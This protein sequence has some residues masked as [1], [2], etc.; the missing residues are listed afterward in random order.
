MTD[1]MTAK[2][3]VMDEVRRAEKS[4]RMQGQ[5]AYQ[6]AG[7]EEIIAELRPSLVRH[8]LAVHPARCKMLLQDK[9]TTSGGKTMTHTVVKIAFRLTHTSGQFEEGESIGEAA[10]NGDKS[11]NKALTA[12]LKYYLLQSFLLQSSYDDPDDYSSDT[13]ERMAHAGTAAPF[14]VQEPA[15]DYNA[16]LGQLRTVTGTALE[17]FRKEGGGLDKNDWWKLAL[18]V[19][20]Q[21]GSWPEPHKAAMVNQLVGCHF[22]R[23]IETG[24]TKAAAEAEASTLPDSW[25]SRLKELA[26]KKQDTPAEPVKEGSGIRIEEGR[27]KFAKKLTEVIIQFSDDQPVKLFHECYQQTIPPDELEFEKSLC[28]VRHLLKLVPEVADDEDQKWITSRIEL[29]KKKL[30]PAYIVP[31]EK[32]FAAKVEELK[33]RK[34][35]Q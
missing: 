35:S 34:V 23:R 19:D 31:L 1:L 21:C 4:R 33:A 32:A 27:A 5:G 28:R 26:T 15:K 18:S 7:A 17:R 2:L 8:G 3:L 24:D 11:C 9:L 14:S 6:Y 12:A 16:L 20:P 22:C 13:G 30:P 10:D 25:K 29:V